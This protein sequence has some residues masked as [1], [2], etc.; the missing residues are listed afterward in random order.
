MDWY[1]KMF[2]QFGMM[3]AL[4]ARGDL[5][6]ARQEA[7]QFVEAALSSADRSLHALAW[8]SKALVVQM[9]DDGQCATA[10]VGKALAALADLESPLVAWRVHSTAGEL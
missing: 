6:H 8:S 7:E 5:E 1:W 10:C 3:S 2:A 9:Q 4:L